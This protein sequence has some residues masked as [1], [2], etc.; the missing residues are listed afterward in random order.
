MLALQKK[1]L[2]ANPKF[3]AL[4]GG[5]AK[6]PETPEEGFNYSG[7]I[8]GASISVVSMAVAFYAFKQCQK[9]NLSST[10]DY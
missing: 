10:D 8:K 4:L 3:L 6:A 1:R 2:L 5:H 7:L 9:K